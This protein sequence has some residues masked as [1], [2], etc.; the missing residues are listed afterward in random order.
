LGEKDGRNQLSL[1]WREAARIVVDC[2]GGIQQGQELKNEPQA[3]GLEFGPE[4]TWYPR[5]GHDAGQE[6]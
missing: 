4:G 3:R 6:V 1:S 5:V 2:A